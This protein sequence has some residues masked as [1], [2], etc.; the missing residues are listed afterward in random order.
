MSEEAYCLD[1]KLRQIEVFHAVFTAGSVSRAADILGVSQ[2]AVSKTLRHL[3]D[4]LHFPLFHRMGRSHG[5]II[6]IAFAPSIAISVGT[7]AVVSFAKDNP[8]IRVE[9]ETLHFDQACEALSRNEIDLAVQYQPLQR[10]RLKS[11]ELAKVNLTCL[12]PPGHRFAKRQT[13]RLSDLKNEKLIALNEDA[14]LGQ[15]VHAAIER[16]G[17]EPNYQVTANTYYLAKELVAKGLGVAI[18]DELAASTRTE[19]ATHSIA[20]EVPIEVSISVMMREQHVTTSP[21]GS[22]LSLVSEEVLRKTCP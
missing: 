14:P 21:E 20:F 22:L 6:R 7:E 19:I 8:N 13:V 2:P 17:E 12:V 1:M 10:A 3:E 11:H 9:F 15:V 18:V 16:D 4:Q 5:K